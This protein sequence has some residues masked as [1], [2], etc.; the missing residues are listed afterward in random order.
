MYY[1][2]TLRYRSRLKCISEYTAAPDINKAA[3]CI[4]WQFMEA[5]WVRLSVYPQWAPC[6]SFRR[7]HNVK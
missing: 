4:L 1:I 2:L 3:K 7:E 6:I 5:N